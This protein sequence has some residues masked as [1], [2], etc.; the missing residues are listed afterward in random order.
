MSSGFYACLS[1]PPNN[2]KQLKSYAAAL[3]ADGPVTT[4]PLPYFVHSIHEGWRKTQAQPSSIHPMEIKV[5]RAAYA[6]LNIP[7]PCSSLRS[8]RIPNQQSCLDTGA[9]LTTV[10]VNILTYLGVKEHGYG[11]GH[12]WRY[13]VGIQG[14]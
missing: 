14:H 5:D 11:G 3:K 7:G 12:N 1:Q 8:R 4:I 9:Q 13:F 10:P 6:D 2:H